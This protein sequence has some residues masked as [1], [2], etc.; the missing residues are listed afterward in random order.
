MQSRVAPFFSII[1]L[2]Q[3]NKQYETK[4]ECTMTQKKSGSLYFMSA[5]EKEKRMRPHM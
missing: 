4:N 3:N 5:N 2:K 1:I